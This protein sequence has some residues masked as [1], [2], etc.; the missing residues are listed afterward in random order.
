MPANQASRWKSHPPGK[1]G[2]WRRPHQGP[3]ADR[4]A[5]RQMTSQVVRRATGCAGCAPAPARPGRSV[6][7]PGATG[8]QQHA[9]SP[10]AMLLNPLPPCPLQR[11]RRLGRQPDRQ[12]VRA[13]VAACAAAKP[14]RHRAAAA[15]TR[16]A[17]AADCWRQQSGE[18]HQRQQAAPCPSQAGGSVPQ[19]RNTARSPLPISTGRK[20]HRTG[21]AR[22][23][24]RCLARLRARV[25]QARGHPLPGVPI[26]PSSCIRSPHVPRLDCRLLHSPEEWRRSTE[27]TVRTRFAP[28]PTGL[29][30]IGG[31]RAALFNYLF[32]RHHGGQYLLRIE[33]TDKQRNTQRGDRHHPGRPGL[34]RPV[35]RRTAGVPVQP[36][37]AR[38]AEIAQDML[39]RGNAYLCYTTPEELAQMREQAA[40]EKP[41]VPLRRALARP[42]SR[43]M[44][45]AGH[46]TGDPPES[47]A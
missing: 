45:P 4:V 39:R 44:A 12:A 34:A 47:A 36:R 32:T 30:H 40:A 33:D 17:P 38:H 10:A 9:L 37:E 26:A 41:S 15:I 21:H 8:R 23:T 42:R 2:G 5:W 7:P 31:A 29:L 18:P 24:T 13:M 27:M 16:R 3:H 46:Q 28:S 19:R 43:P 11:S 25:S 35:A 1:A 6:P 20:Q 22:P 14:K